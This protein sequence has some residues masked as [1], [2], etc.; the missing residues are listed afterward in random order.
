M[1]KVDVTSVE[2]LPKAAEGLVQCVRQAEE[3]SGLRLAQAKKLLE[4]TKQEELASS[5]MLN[6]AKQAEMAAA[7]AHLA[8]EG[9]AAKAAAEQAAAIASGNPLLISAA[10]ASVA[11][12]AADLS[13]A[14]K[15]HRE[16]QLHRERLEKRYKLSLHCVSMAEHMCRDLELAFRAGISSM[17]RCAGEG[18]QRLLAAYE[19]LRQYTS[20]PAPSVELMTISSEWG[21]SSYSAGDTHT[22][23]MTEPE[24]DG[25]QQ[26]AGQQSQQPVRP[27]ELRDKLR[28]TEDAMLAVLAELYATDAGFRNNVLSY[29]A[30][31]EM[32]GGR[33]GAE[34]KIKKTM[35]G[36]LSEEIVKQVFGAL[37]ESVE[38]QN[39]TYTEDGRYTKTDLIVRRLKRP[40]I[41]GRGEGMGAR[42]GSDLAIEVKSGKKEYLSQQLEHMQFQAQGHR[43]C[44]ISCTVCSRDIKE[45][46]EVREAQLRDT[47]R[48]AGSPLFGVLPYK[49]EID[50]A[51]IRFVFGREEDV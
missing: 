40:L 38:T 31:A 7:A 33:S 18:S 47:M 10:A 36:R 17:R 11:K 16:A 22:D 23:A 6:T 49:N 14:A 15:I 5:R 43:A 26:D 12:A 19:K 32:P 51:C 41:L 20:L 39:R 45:L 46:G 24:G 35:A 44:D 13:R 42:E 27:D 1:G 2:A 28:M 37:G 30:Q 3:E 34:I 9:E 8:A 4:N 48:A 25:A 50:R 21:H 29:R